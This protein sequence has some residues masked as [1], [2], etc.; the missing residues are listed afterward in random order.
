M[1]ILQT[2]KSITGAPKMKI[3]CT[4][5]NMYRGTKENTP[6]NYESKL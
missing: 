1:K 5:K 4:L 2:L 6:I 3:P